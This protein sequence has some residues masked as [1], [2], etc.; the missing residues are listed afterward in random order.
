MLN[1]YAVRPI[2]S[3][4]FYE[5]L[6]DIQTRSYYNTELPVDPPVIVTGGFPWSERG[7]FKTSG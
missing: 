7:S 2:G 4:R 5:H 6:K 1:P 3:E